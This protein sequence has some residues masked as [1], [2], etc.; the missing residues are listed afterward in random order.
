[1]TPSPSND[2]RGF[3]AILL[4]GTA[5]AVPAVVGLLGF[6]NP[7][8][9]G[10][11]DDSTSGEPSGGFIRVARLGD[12]K[13]GDPPKAFP[14]VSERVDAWTRSVEPVGQV[15][16]RRVSETEVVALQ[17]KCP[18]EGCPVRVDNENGTLKFKCTC[19][20]AVFDADGKRLD[21]QHSQSPRDLDELKWEVRGEQV[22]VEYKEF[23]TGTPD[24]VA[25]T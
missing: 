15:L 14:V 16:L 5:C 3:L 25:K 2:R 21:P 7:W 10:P 19:H 17:V 24:K 20:T 23:H 4:A 12:M 9:K 18:H 11:A 13:V 6:L 1:M 22:W 8:R